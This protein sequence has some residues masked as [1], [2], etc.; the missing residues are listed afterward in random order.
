MSQEYERKWQGG[1]P[2]QIQ[3]LE[4]LIQYLTKAF[5]ELQI[6]FFLTGSTASSFYGAPRSTNDVDVVALLEEKHI[7]D[8]FR[9]FPS[10][11]F[12][13]S[14]IAIHQAIRD[15][16]QFNILHPSSGLK[17]DVMIPEDNEFNA[18]RFR[19]KKESV[20][21]TEGMT[22]IASEDDVILMKMK[23]YSEGGSDKHL[24]DIAGIIAFSGNNIDLEYLNY[25]ADRLGVNDI[26]RKIKNKSGL[27]KKDD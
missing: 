23:Y 27:T 1:F 12:Y 19:R 8:L 4:N 22:A 11:D 25:W 6:D 3:S 9:L 26:W 18:S 13:L 21:L 10:T 5:R 14:D 20:P 2:M 17:I 7:T 16:S 15:R 24:A